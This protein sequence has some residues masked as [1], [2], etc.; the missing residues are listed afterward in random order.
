MPLFALILGVSAL[1]VWVSNV[2]KTSAQ[3]PAHVGGEPERGAG[4]SV[5]S[6][7]QERWGRVECIARCGSGYCYGVRLRNGLA[8]VLRDDELVR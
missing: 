8:V 6:L 7:P 1:L 5:F 3:L 4:E 2:G